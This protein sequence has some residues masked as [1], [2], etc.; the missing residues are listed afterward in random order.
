MTADTF[1]VL[2]FDR[3][4]G[5]TD[6][7]QSVL[8]EVLQ[9]ETG[10]S[11][12]TFR[13]ARTRIEGEGKTFDTIRHVHMLLQEADSSITWEFIRGRLIERARSAD[14]LLPQ[15]RE[16]LKALDDRSLYYGIITYGVEE[17][18]QLTKLEITGLLPIPHLVTHIEEKGKLLTGWKQPDGTFIVPPALTKEFQPLTVSRLVFL[19]DKAKSFWG[20]PEG[21]EGVH[22]V[23]PGGNKLPAQQGDIPASVTD[24]EGMAGAIS[25]LFGK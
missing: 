13:A 14:L 21:V 20:I 24:V 25:L 19:D 3:C 7:I 18:W 22:V 1:Y 23:A 15:A 5:N 17:A 10:I 6:G 4:I 2:D 12:E 9:T 11:P 8:E 16:L